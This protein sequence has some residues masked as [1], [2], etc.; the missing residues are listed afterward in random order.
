LE[1]QRP[2][3]GPRPLFDNGLGG[4]TPDG[5][6][7]AIH[8]EAGA[9]T[10]APWSNVLANDEFGCVVTEAG[11]GFSW[12]ENSGENRLTPWTNDPVADP[13]S[14]TLYLRD[15]QG[16]EIWTVTP[17]PAGGT[18]ACQ[19]RHGAGYSL[20]RGTVRI[21]QELLVFVPPGAPRRSRLRL[22]PLAAAARRHDL[23]RGWLLGALP[24]CRAPLVC[25]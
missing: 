9:A 24:A 25:Q 6:E 16:G 22:E 3:C 15:E 8:L 21:G 18:S 13:P 4:F 23:L 1:P 19:V 5:S 12:C 2:S 17:E 20:W 14:E 10:P 11:G 7:Y